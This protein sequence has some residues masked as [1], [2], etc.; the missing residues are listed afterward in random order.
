MAPSLLWAV[1]L[2]ASSASGGDS[3]TDSV[4]VRG[5]SPAWLPMVV[6]HRMLSDLVDSTGASSR[7]KVGAGPADSSRLAIQGTKTIQVGIGGDGGVA[8]EQTLFLTA[9]GT[10]RPGVELDARISDGNLPLSAQ[11]SSASLREVDEIWIDVSTLHWGTRLGDQ[12]WDLSPGLAGG[13]QRR[14]RGWSVLWRNDDDRIQGVVGGPAARWVRSA[15]DGVDG[16]QE[17]YALVRNATDARGAV[18]PGSERVRL[19]GELLTSGGDADYQVRYLEGRLDFTP[20]RRIHAGDRIEVEFQAAD[21]D[22]ERTFAGARTQGARGALRWEA[23]ALQEG[24]QPDHALSYTSDSATDR[25]LREAGDDSLRARDPQ[26]NLIPMARQVGEAGLRGNWGDS[27]LWIRSDFRGSTLNRNLSSNADPTREGLF[28][29]MSTGSRM[30]RFLDHGGTGLWTV[31]AR[32]DHL[33][34][35]YHG[36]SSPDTLG[37]GSSDWIQGEPGLATSQERT[38]G[39]GALSWQVLR[40]VGT[41]GEAGGQARSDAFLSRGL[42]RTGVD[43]DADRQFLAEAAWSRRDQGG[44]PWEATRT[45]G[46]ASWPLGDWVP[47]LEAKSELA[48]PK[49]T[50]MGSRWVK[51]SGEGGTRW[52]PASDWTLDLSTRLGTEAVGDRR[53][54]DG[55][56]DT[57]R[58]NGAAG[59]AK[60]TPSL[61]S[62][63]LDADWE[64]RVR[65]SAERF[66]WTESDNWLG[67][68]TAAAWP[69]DGLRGTGHWRLSSTAFQPEVPAYDTVPKGT[70]TYVWDSLLRAVVPSDEGNLRYAGTKLDTSVPAVRA[71]RKSLSGDMEIVPIKIR[72]G[73]TGLIADLGG[74]VHGQWDQTDSVAG[75]FPDFDDASLEQ[76][77]QASSE[78][79]ADLWWTHSPHRLDLG[80][81]RRFA[82]GAY[83]A[84]SV[85]RDLVEKFGW[86][87]SLK[88]GH[89]LLLSGEH[90]NLIQREPS[91]RREEIRWRLDPSVGIRVAKGWEVRPGWLGQWGDGLQDKEAFKT[92][93]NS[94]YVVATANLP[95]GIKLRTEGRRAD[96]TVDGPSG[97][98]L[99]D[100]YPPG[101]TWRAQAGLDW[102]WKDKVQANLDWTLRDEPDRP[103]FQKLSAQARA[104][105]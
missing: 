18:V 85:E 26:G 36:I 24:D 104:N 95:K 34:E 47:R 101:R 2:V 91:Y 74:R 63:D 72:P 54:T 21:L 82:V 103:M 79:G 97:T 78:I 84:G 20:R 29:A 65:R 67:E 10:L 99:T 62:L 7:G 50:G 22:Y 87:T 77:P 55:Q 76:C 25:I 83:T 30:G 12:D 41:W 89:R 23:W 48:T 75:L 33:Q 93:L 19:N 45:R 53:R 57:A 16:Q 15:I 31:W 70:G 71:N 1:A 40:G 6:Q 43:L 51:L 3:L 66:A 35:D 59:S 92:F 102:A 38:T 49:D 60:W 94:P 28:L 61:G 11:G 68:A 13:F 14:L 37:A 8:M 56:F 4:K 80:W 105:F 100:G 46:R 5:A 98:R 73:L 44:L 52:N 69:I 27:T 39:T 81:N 42:V 32:G 90:G 88:S 9:K 86:N 17:G 64:N 96:A 58:W